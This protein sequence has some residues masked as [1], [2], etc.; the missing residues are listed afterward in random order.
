MKSLKK[1]FSVMLALVVLIGASLGVSEPVE[2]NAAEQSMKSVF[3]I[4]AGRKYFSLEQLKEIVDKAYK[5]GYTDVQ[6]LLG[7]DALRLLLDDMSLE[8][9]GHSYSSKELKDAILEGN[10][11][12]YNDPNGNVLTQ[13]EM[14]SLLAFAKERNIRLIPVIN[15]PGHMDAVLVAMEKLGIEKPQFNGSKRTV[16]IGNK[17]AVEFTKALIG[18]YVNYFSKSCEIFNFGADEYANDVD[19]GGWAKLQSSGLYSEFVKYVNDLAAIIKKSGMKPLCFNDGIYYNSTDE[20]GTFDKDI[21]ISY[22]TAGWWGYYV[23]KPQY[24][25]E[26]GHKILNTNDGWYWVLGNINEGGY[27]YKGTLKNIESKEFTDVPAGNDTPIIGSMQC[28]WCDDP[29]Q[30]HDME[31]ILNLMDVFSEKHSKYF[32]RPADYS[33]VDAAIAKIPEDLSIYTEETVKNLTD[34]KEAVVRGKKV[35]EQD[36]VDGYAKAIE[37]AVKVL[38]YKKADYSKVDAAIAKAE[39]LNKNEYKDFSKVTS[40]INAVTRD[41]KITEQAKVDA[42]AISIEEAIKGLEKNDSYIQNTDSNTQNKPDTQDKPVTEDKQNAGNN[43]KPGNGNTESP[44]TGDG[45]NL[46]LW[47]SMLGV[48]CGLFGFIGWKRRKEGHQA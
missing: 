4:D 18:K 22:W 36:I 15:S 14:D 21:I 20:Y 30:E 3:S 44:K 38:E 6:V 23:A 46:A 9:N 8:V 42:M 25:V 16:D 10:K 37:D 19:T 27:N 29:T 28:V 39:S 5:N 33:K 26:K 24:F 35:N 13:A 34:V 7:N 17:E 12:Y 45:T 47:M 31:R 40:A 48:S 11:D 43:Y 41:M 1:I 2:V 32:I